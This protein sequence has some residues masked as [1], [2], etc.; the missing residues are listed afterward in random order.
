MTAIKD[1]LFALPLLNLLLIPALR[2][3]WKTSHR[4]DTIEYNQRRLCD[5]LGITYIETRP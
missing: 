5:K 4:I 3:I 1:V 2:A